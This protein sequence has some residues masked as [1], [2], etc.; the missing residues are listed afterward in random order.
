MDIFRR[1]FFV[2]VLSGAMAGLLSAAIQQWRGVPLIL[3]AELYENIEHS[4]GSIAQET[5]E[6]EGAAHS[7]VDAEKPHEE[8]EPWAP[9]DGFERTLF[10]VLAT[11]L[12]SL[13]FAFLIAAGSI[14]TNIS[15][16]P[17]NGLLWGLSGF[18]AFSLMPSIGLSPELPGMVAAELGAR[19]IWW[20]FTAIATLAAILALLKLPRYAGLGVGLVLITLPHLMG[21]PVPPH[22]PSNVPP[23][24]SSTF[25]ANALFASLSFWLVLGALHGQF[26][27]IFNKE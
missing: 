14:L 16:T 24:L 2:V 15:V 7:Q 10:T 1:I 23:H 11:M 27:Q 25:A 26:N 8:V 20:W 4:H 22:V 6:N 19:Q 3:E 21:S 17:T 18:A 5:I 12:V 9:Q 13:G